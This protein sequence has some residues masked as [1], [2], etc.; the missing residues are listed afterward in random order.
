MDSQ[1]LRVILDDNY[2]GIQYG[3]GKW[4]VSSLVQWYQGTSAY[5]AFAGSGAFGTLNLIFEGDSF[6]M[7]PGG[8]LNKR[9]Y[10]DCNRI[11]WQHSRRYPFTICDYLNRWRG[12]LQFELW[13]QKR[14]TIIYSVVPITTPARWKAQYYSG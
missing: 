9:L 13:T 6:E 14:P 1:E 3:G 5:P 10:R 12:S 4:T 8:P 7:F 11:H 2:G